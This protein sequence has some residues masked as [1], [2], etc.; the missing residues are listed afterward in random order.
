[1]AWWTEARFGTFLCL[2]PFAIKGW[3]DAGWHIAWNDITWQQ[4]R[5][6]A[7]RFNP[8][9]FD[10]AA[11]ARQIRNTGFRYV[12]FTAKHC[13][14]FSMFDTGQSDWGIMHT[15]YGKDFM[16]LLFDALRAEGLRV[17]VYFL[18]WDWSRPEYRGKP[19][20]AP[21]LQRERGGITPDGGNPQWPQYL[22]LYLAQVNEIVSN[23]GPID[24]LWIDGWRQTDTDRWASDRLHGLVRAKQPDVLLNDRW[25]DVERAD[26]ITPENYIPSRD[27]GR[28]W[29]TCYRSNGGW[30]YVDRPYLPARELVGMLIECVSKNGN[31]LLNV[32]LDATGRYDAAAVE[33]MNEIG[34]WLNGNGKAV[35]GCGAAPLRTTPWGRATA[36]PGHV[37]LHVFDDLHDPRRPLLV[38][39]LAGKV[40]GARLLADGRALDIHRDGDDLTIALPEGFKLDPIATVIDVRIDD[41]APTARPRFIREW[42]VL[43]PIPG[44][45]GAVMDEALGPESA[46]DAARPLVVDGRPYAWQPATIRPDGCVD[47][48]TLKG[49]APDRATFAVVDVLCEH[50]LSTELLFGSAQASRVYL[51]G[52]LVAA[53]RPTPEARSIPD[54][55]RK[56][57]QLAAGRNTLVAKTHAAGPPWGFYAW[58]GG[59][60][61]MQFEPTRRAAFLGGEPE[62]WRLA[63]AVIEAEA[64]QQRS[65]TDLVDGRAASGDFLRMRPRG[66]DPRTCGI[67]TAFVLKRDLPDACVLIRYGHVKATEMA[68]AI[69]DRK[70]ITVA[71]PSTG[72]WRV[73]G[74][75]IAPVGPLSAGR[76]TLS[77]RCLKPEAF[78]LDT[79]VI[80]NG[81]P[82]GTGV[83]VQR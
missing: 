13:S 61:R 70:P 12:V 78:H 50:D 42:T 75:A 11:V 69:D 27:Q 52:S 44:R 4:T 28:P 45:R 23:Y 16:R 2:D 56:R 14:G 77:L 59:G 35:Y 47:L 3:G 25:G 63:A 58:I 51:N 10:P 38:E 21:N 6:L 54:R 31:L 26:F 79:V 83:R 74:A 62:S 36:K 30:Y 39:G 37:Y 76:H 20:D 5:E 22:E 8:S 64:V 80:V 34:A 19:I 53:T 17:G 29:E 32:A 65:E 57:I 24:V 49:A 41:A 33:R 40:I 48:A 43:S 67:E 46:M 1:M 72:G 18:Q 66:D 15:P 55:L 82:A 68:L 9:Q 7:R 73:Y 60:S 71:M 81:Q